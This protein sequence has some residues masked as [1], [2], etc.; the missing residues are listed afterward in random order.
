MGREDRPAVGKAIADGVAEAIREGKSAPK[1]VINQLMQQTRLKNFVQG[2]IWDLQ[3]PRD[4]SGQHVFREE[5]VNAA[6]VAIGIYCSAA[7]IPFNVALEGE[8]FYSKQA[9]SNF[10]NV[11]MDRYYGLPKRN[12]LNT[13]LGYDLE[14]YNLIPGP[15]E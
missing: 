13:D 3:R 14:R 11:A 9:N 6:T 10:G 15:V 8:S 4:N 5:F 7:G 2:G 1:S 12:V